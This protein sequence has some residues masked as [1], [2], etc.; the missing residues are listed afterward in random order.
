[1]QCRLVPFLCFVSFSVL[2]LLVS[3]LLPN[4]ETIEE[5]NTNGIRNHLLR[6]PIPSYDISSVWK[7]RPSDHE[8]KCE[9]T[10]DY[11][12]QLEG[13][14]WNKW[15]SKSHTNIETYDGVK[16]RV[17]CNNY[18]HTGRHS[19]LASYGSKAYMNETVKSECDVILDNGYERGRVLPIEYSR[20][21]GWPH[22]GRSS[23]VNKGYSL[24]GD[25]PWT[26]D[27]P[28]DSDGEV[29]ELSTLELLSI[30]GDGN[31]MNQFAVN[32]GAN[33]G[34][35]SVRARDIYICLFYS[36]FDIS[37]FLY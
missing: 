28:L 1:M 8:L 34:A 22:L 6:T 35:T 33:D 37:C 3:S 16:P 5:N 4:N 2:Y 25:S 15:M 26:F 18:W 27:Y 20:M 19:C 9:P 30:L 29:K 17:P 14:N 36:Q 24:P 13:H 11:F 7:N 12:E 21:E 31:D 23:I 32:L 10:N